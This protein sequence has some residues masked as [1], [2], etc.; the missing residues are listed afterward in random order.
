MREVAKVQLKN[1]RQS[2]RKVR[3]V[4]DMIRNM[5]VDEAEKQLQLSVKRPSDPLLTLLR[6]AR[7]QAIDNGH[8]SDVLI[9]S[10]ICVNAGPT[11]RRYTPRAFGRAYPIRKRS[12]H[13]TLSLSV[14]QK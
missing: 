8:T 7:A 11:L 6:S 5:S 4:A 3:L 10:A 9:V 1:L 12:A 13:I 2:P 14:N